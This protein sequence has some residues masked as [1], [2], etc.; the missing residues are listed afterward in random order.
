MIRVH[1]DLE[2]QEDVCEL[3]EML[4]AVIDHV[5]HLIEFA[6]EDSQ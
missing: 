4:V 3:F 6:R 5:Q 2:D 1:L